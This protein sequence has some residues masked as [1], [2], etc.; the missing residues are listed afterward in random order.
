MALFHACV[1]VLRAM[2]RSRVVNVR[3]LHRRPRLPS[4]EQP[5]RAVT[6]RAYL[7]RAFLLA[8]NVSRWWRPHLFGVRGPDTS[9]DTKSRS[10]HAATPRADAGEP[11][12]ELLVAGCY[13]GGRTRRTGWARC[14]RGGKAI[15]RSAPPRAGIVVDRG[16]TAPTGLGERVTDSE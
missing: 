9:L 3:V 7:R 8:A 2:A 13:N 16:R 12:H 5:P 4:R 14:G 15:G 11:A 6:R 1:H 10:N